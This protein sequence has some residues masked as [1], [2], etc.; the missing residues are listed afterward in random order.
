MRGNWKR[1]YRISAQIAKFY[2]YKYARIKK[3]RRNLMSNNDKDLQI[4]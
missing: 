4:T 1:F 3:E 2:I